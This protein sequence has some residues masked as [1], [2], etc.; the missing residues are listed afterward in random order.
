M[1][2]APLVQTCAKQHKIILKYQTNYIRLD[3]M[4]KFLHAPKKKINLEERVN[5]MPDGCKCSDISRA[6]VPVI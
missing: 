1:Q 4:G 6:D 5:A 2:H 3:H